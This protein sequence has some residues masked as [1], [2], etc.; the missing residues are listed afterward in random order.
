MKK[1]SFKKIDLIILTVILV[2]A[3]FTRLYKINTPLADFHS[4]RQVDT[5]A[6]ARN[7]VD[8][9]FDLLHPRYD[10]LSNIQS[11]LENPNGYR[12]V[13]FPIYNAIFASLYKYFP[14]VSLEIYG[15][16]TTIMFS[17]IIIGIIY[18]LLLKETSRKTAI[19]ASLTY[20]IFPYFVFFSRVV[21]P[22][23][24]AL[25]FIF[26]SI[27]F[28]YAYSN[29]KKKITSSLLYLLSLSFFSLAIITKPTVIFYGITL[30]YLFFR[31]HKL[32][33]VK[34][35][36]F[37]LFFIISTIP[38]LLWYYYISHFPEGVPANHWLITSVNTPQGLRSI[39]FR[40]AFFRWIF[41]E[42]INNLIFG[43]YLSFLFLLGIIRKNKSFFYS[44][45]LFS[46]LSFL[47]IFQGGNVQHEYYQT[48]ILPPL[49]IFVG[50]GTTL[51]IKNK[52][53]FINQLILSIIIFA[54]YSSSFFFSFYKVRDYYNFSSDL[55]HI[56]KIVKSLTNKK[57]KII[58]ESL[59]DTTLLY[60][61]ERK[62]SPSQFK[63]LDELKKDGYKYFVISNQETIKKLKNEKNYQFV[64]ENN[65]FALLKL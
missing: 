40:P 65:K 3:L 58:T 29:N 4:W 17:L 15:R 14:I 59:G 13:E 27:F 6:V 5:A 2:I 24:T 56:S 26:L 64:F 45:F 18:Y 36:Y 63:P 51:L 53:I 1:K 25:G 30:G 48:I 49:A 11:G 35:I 44:T 32:Q 33:I 16:L 34:K 55:I 62:G 38:Y 8:Q 20:A 43:G 41:F 47:F 52:K 46:I 21:L 10:D 54:I 28:L 61:S 37:Y 22:E 31:K 42:R 57:D 23:T 60:L 39:F 9:G 7:F 50:L 19:F 12:F